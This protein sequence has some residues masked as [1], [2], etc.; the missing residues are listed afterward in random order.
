VLGLLL[1]RPGRIVPAATLVSDLWGDS[2]PSRAENSIQVH[3]SRLRRALPEDVLLTRAP[4]YLLDVD[5]ESVDA[6]RFVREAV[7]AQRA[8]AFGDAEPAAA[9]AERALAEWRGPIATGS[10]YHGE[11]AGEVTRLDEL[12]LRLSELR[13]EVQLSLHRHGELVG[14]LETLIA[15]Y[16]LHEPFRRQLMLAL[17]RSGRQAEALD[18]YARTRAELVELAGIDPGPELQ[19]LQRAL[20]RQDESLSVPSRR[21]P[22]VAPRATTVRK[23]ITAVYA[24][25]RIAADEL[26]DPEREATG[27]SEL[28]QAL[29]EHGGTALD[30]PGDGVVALYGVPQAREDDAV[31]AARGALACLVL[32]PTA[33]I[34]IASGDALIDAAGGPQGPVVR[35]AA[36]LAHGAVPGAALL[37]AST[38]AYLQDAAVTEHYRDRRGSLEALRLVEVLPGALPIA[39]RHD[40]PLV[41]RVAE[42]QTL[43]R[44]FERAARESRCHLL[45]LLGDAGIGKSRLAEELRRRVGDASVTVTGRCPADEA[46]MPLRPLYEIVRGAAGEVTV[47]ALTELLAGEEDARELAEK[48]VVAFGA[49][50]TDEPLELFWAFRRFFETLGRRGPTVVFLEDLHWAEPTLLELVERLSDAIRGVPLLL[51][52]LARP[53]LLERRPTWGGGKVS[54]TT[55]LLEPLNE[56]ESL[57]LIELRRGSLELDPATRAR[58]AERAEGNPLYIEQVIAFLAGSPAQ[59]E[60][61]IPPTIHALLQAR[62]D[63]LDEDERRLLQHGAVEGKEFG[64]ESIRLM[65]GEPPDDKLVDRLTRKELLER[66]TG[67]TLRF[68][69]TTIREVAYATLPKRDRARLHEAL[70]D[71]L[72][73]AD[74]VTALPA[75][76][77]VAYHLEQALELRRELGAGEPVLQALGERAGRRLARAGRRAHARSEI[78][79]A[80]EL[81][82]RAAAYDL[83]SGGHERALLLADLGE[84]L[85]AGGELEAATARLAE[86][87]ALAEAAGDEPAVRRAELVAL[88]IQLFTDLDLTSAEVVPIAERSVAAFERAGDDAGLAQVWYLLGWVAWLSCRADEALKALEPSI[89]HAEAAGSERARAQALHLLVGAYL[90]GPVPAARAIERCEA[91]LAQSAEQRRI[92]ASA[93]RALAGLYAMSGR[94]ERA[95]ELIAVDRAIVDDLGLRVSA[96]SAAEIYGWVYLLEGRLEEAESEYRRGLESLYEIGDLSSASTLAA[97]LAQVLIAQGRTLEAAETAEESRDHASP[98]DLQTQIQ[99]RGPYAKALARQ[100]KTEPA[101]R[102]AHEA[103]VLARTTDFLNVQAAALAD[104]GEALRLSGDQERAAQVTQRALALY[105]R[106]GNTAAA[107]ALRGGPS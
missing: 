52:C 28:R 91:V 56:T 78:R 31:R 58:I 89:R 90:F 4:G 72:D 24:A 45:T 71:W 77:A 99:W 13:V 37:S 6:V 80:I 22:A 32:S 106:K 74:R 59:A 40:L 25:V 88:R 64:R 65:L 21:E 29:T 100:G 84:A 11:A 54:S 82:S 60:P 53:E 101:R 62:L 51:V 5:P 42:L 14:E 9:A 63:A 105:E 70:A 55:L 104:L 7:D 35:E 1:L 47:Q 41:G 66:T 39:R 93:A 67:D 30:A 38:A 27:L 96:A 57:E 46:A 102:I 86:A 48:L 49:G 10:D 68:R 107:S 34:G 87:R 20:L 98:D 50:E 92:V 8:F 2:P 95:H 81:L 15:A 73:D 75:D 61:S 17:Y 79:H 44:A 76:E 85:R 3:I 43:E 36:R 18:A 33:S 83:D 19:E 94:F 23:T 12:R 97:G 16:P 103:I 26:Y 69:H